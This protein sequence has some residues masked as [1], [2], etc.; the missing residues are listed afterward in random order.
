MRSII[1][2]FTLLLCALAFNASS[3]NLTGTWQGE[4]IDDGEFLQINIV[5]TGNQLC[6]YTWDY[7]FDDERSYCKAYFKGAY[8]K[9]MDRYFMDG[10]SFIAN[11]GTHVL[12]QIMIAVDTDGKG[13]QHMTGYVRTKS[14]YLGSP[15]RIELW[16]VAKKPAMMTEE[17]KNCI[18]ENQPKKATPKP[19]VPKPKPVTPK[20]IPVKPVPVKPV[21]VKPKPVA[22]K[23]DS[24]V[25]IPV[26]PKKTDTVTPIKIK[27]QLPPETLPQ[28]TAGRQNKEIGRITVHEK[29]ITLNVYDNAEVDG[30]SV[31]IYYNGRLIRSHVRLTEKPIVLDLDLDEN[32]N[33]HTVVMYAENLGSIPP[34]T[35]L[36][37]FYDPK[38]KRYQLL[39]RSTFDQNAMIVFE[40]KP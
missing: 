21:P 1:T 29:K 5:Q 22:P 16:K 39:A 31:S 20:P 18:S 8:N 30:D 27:P 33:L 6:G 15:S 2:I 13:R 28:S 11:S 12:M 9:S 10:Y 26:V 38:G 7:V 4:I 35:A 17:M 40:Y 14:D 36:M 25:K 34:N 24:A 32:R 23:K 37:I 3:Q 19:V